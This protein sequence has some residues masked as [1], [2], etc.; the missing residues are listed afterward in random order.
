MNTLSQFDS[1]LPIRDTL[2]HVMVVWVAG[3]HR[4]VLPRQ[5]YGHVMVVWVAGVHR[6]DRLLPFTE[7]FQIVVCMAG[8]IELFLN[9]QKTRTIHLL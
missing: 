2:G 4:I 6:I 5:E 7:A 1:S 9:V 3:V 8:D